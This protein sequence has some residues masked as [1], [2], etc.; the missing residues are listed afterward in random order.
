MSSFRFVLST[1]GLKWEQISC[2][3]GTI[4]AGR[5]MELVDKSPPDD[6][7]EQNRFVVSDL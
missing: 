6:A 7:P 1:L 5:E 4:E 2:A 3:A